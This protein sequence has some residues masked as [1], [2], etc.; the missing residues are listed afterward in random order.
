VPIDVSLAGLP[1]EQEVLARATVWTRV[2]GTSLTTCRA[3]DLVVYE[4]VAARPQDLVDVPA[5]AVDQGTATA[6][7][8]FTPNR[9]A[10]V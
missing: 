4:L 6:S 9:R 5:E 7:S 8:T 2:G 1:F 10:L 3:E